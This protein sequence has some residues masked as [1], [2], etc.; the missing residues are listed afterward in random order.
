MK[1][2]KKIMGVTCLVLASNAV[3]AEKISGFNFGVQ[4][5]Y[6]HNKLDLD[7]TYNNKKILE[8]DFKGSRGTIGAFIGYDF[9]LSRAVTLGPE[10]FAQYQNVRMKNDKIKSAYT[11]MKESFG[12]LVRLGYVQG[13]VNPYIK[14]GYV[15]TK[16]IANADT[17]DPEDKSSARRSGWLLGAGVDYSLSDRVSLGVEYAYSRYSF[18]EEI[19]SLKL[20]LKSNV[21]AVNVRLKYRI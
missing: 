10:F 9:A 20:D 7:V 15:N 21:N 17:N 11:E 6:I 19:S 8:E 12:A 14:G 4:G 2:L 1:N 13:K 18:D 3:A 5:G 16:F